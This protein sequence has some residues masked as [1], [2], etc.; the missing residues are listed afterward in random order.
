M[1]SS[2][3][4]VFLFLLLSHKMLFKNGFHVLC[5]NFNL[6]LFFFFFFFLLI[7]CMSSLCVLDINPLSGIF[8]CTYL[9]SFN[10]RSFCSIASFLSVQKLELLDALLL[11]FFSVSGFNFHLTIC[12]LFFTIWKIILNKES[13]NKIRV[14]CCCCH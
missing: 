10:R 1:L 9:L 13:G 6:V 2:Q 11:S 12:I 8:F 4:T 5:L 3:D 14:E 7:T